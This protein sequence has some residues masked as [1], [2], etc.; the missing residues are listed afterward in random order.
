MRRERL[1]GDGKRRRSKRNW[2]RIKG[3]GHWKEGRINVGRLNKYI[4]NRK[5]EVTG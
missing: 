5:N 3:T 1:A 2:T 4:G